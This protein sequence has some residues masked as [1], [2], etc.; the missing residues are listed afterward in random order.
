MVAGEDRAS[1]VIELP[2]AI[3]TAISLSEPLG[4]VPALFDDVR[5]VTVR[6]G[7]T[8]GPTEFPH[9]FKTLFIVYELN[10]A[11]HADSLPGR[12]QLPGIQ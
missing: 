7:R 3:Q 5:C 10:Q 11:Q 12:P 2:L 9:N 8:I 4:V 6:A 1:E